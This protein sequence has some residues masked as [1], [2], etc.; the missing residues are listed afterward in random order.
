[1]KH[2]GDAALNQLEDVL[3]ELRRNPGL[4]EKK[5]GV[6][7]RGASAFLHFHE[8]SAGLFV[9]VRLGPDW[10]RLPINTP[11]EKR[12]LLSKVESA[13]RTS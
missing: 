5:R 7:Y 6:F 2:A 13:T 12:S 3:V 10:V 11:A 1:M 9:D 4:K 8:D